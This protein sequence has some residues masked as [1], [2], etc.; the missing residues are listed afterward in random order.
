[1]LVIFAVLNCS[2]ADDPGTQLAIPLLAWDMEHFGR[3]G[4]PVLLRTY[5]YRHEL[6]ERSKTLLIKAPPKP[7]NRKVRDD[8]IR[9][10]TAVQI[11]DDLFVH[12]GRKRI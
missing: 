11:P 2:T 3:C 6:E 9:P 12:V 10:Y 8:N 4:N 1:M 7:T 5:E